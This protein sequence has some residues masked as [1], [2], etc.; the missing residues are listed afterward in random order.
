M[1]MPDPANVP[2]RVAVVSESERQRSAL[3]RILHVNGLQVL[4]RTADEWLACGLSRELA[5][6]VLVDLEGAGEP[7]L[8]FVD[9]L[10]VRTDLPILFNEDTAAHAGTAEDGGPW[11]RRLAAKLNGLALERSAH[12]PATAPAPRRAAAPA[13]TESRCAPDKPALRLIEPMAPVQQQARV[14]PVRVKARRVWVLGASIGGPQA[15]RSFL[16]A[17]P[18]DLEVALVLAQHIGPGFVD[19]LAGQLQ[20]VTAFEVLRAQHG[21]PL[22]H[23]QLVLTPVK[24]SLTIDA[25]GSIQL[26]PLA[27]SSVYNPSIDAVMSAVAQRYGADAGAILFSGMGDDGVRGAQRIVEHGGVVWAQDP[28]S[29]VISSMVD[30]ARRVG[31]VS[32]TA[33]P[34]ELAGHL[35]EY[36]KGN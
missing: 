24:H 9:T 18:G 13:Q 17:L 2:L 35:V 7:T 27:Q 6:V 14:E 19:L 4:T 22:W 31:V 5:E 12:K 30:T 23:G 15:V 32:F 20:R 21:Q 11:G 10:I 36:L 26:E 16:G 33:P 25:E 34:D 29:C 1:G 8:A 3:I 28:A